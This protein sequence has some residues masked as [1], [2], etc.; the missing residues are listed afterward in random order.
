MFFGRPNEFLSTYKSSCHILMGDNFNF[1]LIDW[2]KEIPN[3]LCNTAETF[4]SQ[5]V[6]HDLTQPVKEPTQIENGTSSI[7]DHFLVSNSILH[8]SPKI[9]VFKGLSDH[10]MA[11]LTMPLKSVTKNKPDERMVPV[12]THTDDVVISDTL[13]ISFSHFVP[14]SHSSDSS[15]D[16]LFFF[17]RISA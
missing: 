5:L 4:L 3:A 13:D 2:D 6:F 16:D 15:V 9:S 8:R 14:L 11:N 1:P 17:L 12:F 10:S 7:L